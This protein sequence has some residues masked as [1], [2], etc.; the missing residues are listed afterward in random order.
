MSKNI[1]VTGSNSGFGRLTAQTLARDGH[2]VFAT[3]RGVAGRN[4]KGAAE[5]TA[6]ARDGGHPLHVV[7]LDVTDT[8][9]VAAAVRRVADTTHGSV[10]VLV[11]NAGQFAAGVLEACTVE[12]VQ[13]LF[14]INVFGPMRVARAVLPYMRERRQGLLV[15]ISSVLGRIS[16]PFMG[17]YCASK[18][19][20]EAIAESY[21]S[22][23][24]TLGI[25]SVIVEPGAFPTEVGMKAQSP[26]DT[27]RLEGYGDLA[28]APQRMFEGLGQLFASPQ[29]PNPQ[30]VA[31]A[32][33]KLVDTP[34]GQRPA[35]TVVDAMTGSIIADVNRAYDASR[36]ELMKAFGM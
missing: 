17:T 29:A 13:A 8:G 28:N 3:M 31:D 35:R 21:R 4:A 12:Q 14:D 18:F 16:M 7:E 5:L 34:F 24:V 11:N 9:S 23:L 2:T 22:E 30:D 6:W 1:I 32:V 19:A 15:Q 20:A 10:D 25:D 26:T 36:A 27:S 33:K